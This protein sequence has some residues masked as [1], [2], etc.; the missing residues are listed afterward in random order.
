MFVFWSIPYSFISRQVAIC[1][2][3]AVGHVKRMSPS[4][5]RSGLRD[6]TFHVASSSN[7]MFPRHQGVE[8]RSVID[9][10]PCWSLALRGGPTTEICPLW[11]RSNALWENAVNS[12]T[13]K[14]AC[15]C[16]T[17][18][19]WQRRMLLAIGIQEPASAAFGQTVEYSTLPW[20]LRCCGRLVER[21]CAGTDIVARAVPQQ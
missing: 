7:A 21:P 5:R 6:H 14:I 3:S 13:L 17:C 1:G 9:T 19:S 11:C 15:S 12:C 2:N 20:C 16:P 18:V 10:G 4:N 8:A